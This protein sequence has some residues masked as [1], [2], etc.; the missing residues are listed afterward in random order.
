[1]RG[2]GLLSL[3]ILG[4][5][6]KAT[7]FFLGHISSGKVTIFRNVHDLALTQMFLSLGCDLGYK[8][9]NGGN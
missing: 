3:S 2:E 7:I 5:V 4:D 1:M 8:T 6:S 9:F